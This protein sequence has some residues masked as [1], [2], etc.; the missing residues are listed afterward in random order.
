[1][2]EFKFICAQPDDTYYTWQ[3]HLWLESL[4]AIG[5]S[6]KAIVLIFTPMGRIQNKNWKQVIDLYP[7]TEFVFYS[8][9]HEVSL[10]LGIYIPILR[11]Y[12]L[13]RY[14]SDH[15]DMKNKG[16]FYC[17]SDIL[18]MEGFDVSKYLE[19]DVCYLSDTNSYINASYFDSKVKDVLPD[20]LEEY[21]K[22]DILQEITNLIGI[23]RNVCELNNLN[24]GGAQ[25]FLKNIDAS[26]WKKV[27]DD[28]IIIRTYLQKINR[29]FFENEN[30]GFQS[31]CADMW[32]IL[33]NLWLRK[34]ETKCVP[35]MNFA[36]ATDSID[37]L[38][39]NTLFHNA[40]IS[41]SFMEYGRD[42]NN[43]AK[44]YPAFYKGKYHRGEDPTKDSHLELILA[45]EE[46]KK[47]CTWFYTSK[48][49]ELSLKYQLN[50]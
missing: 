47:R 26:F 15:P 24:S 12:S 13:W 46:S 22:R 14:F 32:A 25:Y 4:R 49:K 9:E 3:V 27:Q 35:E 37:K 10:L 50:Y 30:K 48:I 19:D 11:P 16:V 44:L 40:G 43:N 2:R 39:T 28:C 7:E 34:Q 21:K 36:W 31:W 38:Q 17:D 33:W 42:E 29:D 45:N 23:N 6:D 41:D 8:D 18:F 20:K 1:M 5:H